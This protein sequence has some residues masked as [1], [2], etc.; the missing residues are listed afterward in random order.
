MELIKQYFK[1]KKSELELKYK[2]TIK[3]LENDRQNEEIINNRITK[4]MLNKSCAVAGFRYC[5]IGC[6]HF[7]KGK[8]QIRDYSVTENKKIVVATRPT[9]KLWTK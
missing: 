3:K 1:N 4:D 7:Q 9:C 8:V 5:E 2:N 6:S